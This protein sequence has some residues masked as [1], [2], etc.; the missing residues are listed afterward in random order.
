M[1]ILLNLVKSILKIIH[2]YNVYAA[3]HILAPLVQQGSSDC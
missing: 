3:L 1:A 2:V